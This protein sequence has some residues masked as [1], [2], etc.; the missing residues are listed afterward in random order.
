MNSGSFGRAMKMGST[1]HLSQGPAADAVVSQLGAHEANWRISRSI[2]SHGT[3]AVVIS[4][5]FPH[6][7][8]KHWHTIL[9][10]TW[11]ASVPCR[12]RGVCTD[13]S[14]GG[15]CSW[16]YT[17]NSRGGNAKIRSVFQVAE[18]RKAV[19]ELHERGAFSYSKYELQASHHLYALIGDVMRHSDVR[20]AVA[21]AMRLSP[22]P[23]GEP[24]LGNTSDY[25]VTAYA[26]GDFLSTHSDGAS[27]TLAFVLH[28]A[29]SWSGASGGSLR[30]N[31]GKAAGVRDFE[32]AFNRMLL[33]MTRPNYTPHQVLSVARER[34][35][36]PRF[37]FT[38]WY[39]TRSD[40]L[41][42]GVL[43]ERDLMI[44]ASSKAG[45]CL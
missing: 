9:N 18:R 45:M 4:D 44:A 21:R 35:A 11:Q 1:R 15:A 2:V 27:G 6:H 31:A 22:G 10:N 14:E 24:A 30:F 5:F 25:F 29:S 28:L 13:G 8:A 37:G 42:P 23:K 26:D 38:G 40:H 7:V 39:M 19:T 41:S 12:E 33:F 34:D 17:T 32:P 43:R 20:G 36:E 16:L 3:E